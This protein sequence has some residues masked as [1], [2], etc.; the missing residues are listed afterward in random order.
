MTKKYLFLTKFD[1][2]QQIEQCEIQCWCYLTSAIPIAS[3]TQLFNV[4]INETNNGVVLI[5]RYMRFLSSSCHELMT[6]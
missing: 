5:F 2:I 3:F 1:E 4:H 6:K